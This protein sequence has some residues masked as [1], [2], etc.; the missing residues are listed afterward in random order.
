VNTV[1][2]PTKRRRTI[3]ENDLQLHCRRL[4]NQILDMITN[5]ISNRFK[6]F[7]QLNFF[8]LMIN[9]KFLTFKQQFPDN[10]LK[11]LL[12]N[13]PQFFDNDKLENE[14]R[15]LYSDP[16]ILVDSVE[17]REKLKFITDFRKIFQKYLS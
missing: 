5:Q 3:L 17:I 16:G 15:V 4:Y 10:L 14:L 2:P 8:N 9:D 11:K 13:Y 1:G 12:D 7:E 6:D